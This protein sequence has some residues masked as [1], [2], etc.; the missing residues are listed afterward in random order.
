[1]SAEQQHRNVRISPGL[2]TTGPGG[3]GGGTSA[4]GGG[5]TS[6]AQTPQVPEASTLW[7]AP[8]FAA[9]ACSIARTG[10]ASERLW[11]RRRKAL[12]SREERRSQ[13]NA[14]ETPG[15]ARQYLQAH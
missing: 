7:Q 4:G 14:V 12:S 9:V 5:G 3:G 10:A 8:C 11:K 6:E 15:S 2:Q 13:G 1:M